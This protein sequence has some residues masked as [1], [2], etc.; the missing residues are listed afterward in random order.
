MFILEI[1]IINPLFL[2]IAFY[3]VDIVTYIFLWQLQKDGH[4]SFDYYY[5]DDMYTVFRVFVSMMAKFEPKCCSFTVSTRLL[6]WP[7]HY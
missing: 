5:T 6:G 4:V 7:L 2:F 3:V 1:C